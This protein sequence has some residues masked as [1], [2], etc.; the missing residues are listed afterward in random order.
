MNTREK[1]WGKGTRDATERSF[2]R[3]PR[4]RTTELREAWRIFAECVK[5]FRHL[6]FVGP[7]VTVFGSARF[8]EDHPYYAL[9][10]ELGTKLAQAGF[11]VMTGGGPGI[12]EAANRGA[13]EGG[14]YSV[15]SNITLPVEQKPNAYLDRW[16]EFRY[17]FVRKMLLEKYSYAFVAMPGGIGT[18]DELFETSV[19]VQTGK[20]QDFP[21]VLMGKSF[22]TPL[23]DYLR[24]GLLAAGTIDASDVSRWLITDSPDEAVETIRARAMS[25]FGLTYGPRAK[26]RWWLGERGPHTP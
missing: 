1:D 26:P 4:P 8:K 17:F 19:L 14:G 16:V 22:W 21:L 3:G 12:M 25:E 15:G 11:T 18:L 7:C 24:G 2:L 6:H 5:G 10:R 23:V 20:M 13:K 9:A